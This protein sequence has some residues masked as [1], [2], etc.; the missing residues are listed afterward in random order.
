[1]FFFFLPRYGISPPSWTSALKR[2]S[3]GLRMK[4]VWRKWVR[5]EKSWDSSDSCA[6]QSHFTKDTAF[7]VCK[8]L[9]IFLDVW[10]RGL[11]SQD[12]CDSSPYCANILSPPSPLTPSNTPRMVSR[13]CNWIILMSLP[14]TGEW[15]GAPSRLWPWHLFS[16]H[17]WPQLLNTWCIAWC[18]YY[19][20]F[21]NYL[22]LSCFFQVHEV[23]ISLS[24]FWNK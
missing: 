18:S 5:T 16:N 4:C 12:K 2:T 24:S 15:G 8:N 7:P 3:W 1:M 19:W 10:P 13:L 6:A 22:T 14:R 17:Y 20:I 9:C 21:Q 23:L 11:C